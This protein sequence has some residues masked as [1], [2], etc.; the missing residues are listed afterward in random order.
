[1][2]GGLGQPFGDGALA[3]RVLKPPEQVSN[4][5]RPEVTK[6][7]LGLVEAIKRGAKT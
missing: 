7:S 4:E 6:R 5:D 1:M 3:S 2:D